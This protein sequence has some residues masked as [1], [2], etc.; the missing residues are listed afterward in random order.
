MITDSERAVMIAQFERGTSPGVVARELIFARRDRRSARE[1]R[2]VAI[3]SANAAA[4]ANHIRAAKVALEGGG[5]APEPVSLLAEEPLDPND[6]HPDPGF[7]R[8][9]VQAFREWSPAVRSAIAAASSGPKRVVAAP[10][11]VLTD[12]LAAII[13][14]L[15]SLPSELELRARLAAS[16]QAVEA[17]VSAQRAAAADATAFSSSVAARRR[18]GAERMAELEREAAAAVSV[19]SGARADA[20][21]TAG[22]VQS[23]RDRRNA[24]EAERRDLVRKLNPPKR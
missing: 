10:D 8:E 18:G 21:A 4:R 14:E 2:N 12:R 19:E 5:A 23:V 3:R 16:D 20:V 6:Q 24:L 9:V 7:H 17:A 1:A 15:R 13:D 22:D 11:P